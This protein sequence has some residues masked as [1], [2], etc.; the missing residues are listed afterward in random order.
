MLRSIA[1]SWNW[2]SNS[3]IPLHLLLLL[4]L[5]AVVRVCRFVLCPS[6][7]LALDSAFVRTKQL[8]IN[9]RL[10]ALFFCPPSDPP[11]HKRCVWLVPAFFCVKR[12]CSHSET[13]E[14]YVSSS[15][16]QGW[17]AEALDVH[18]LYLIT[19][20]RWKWKGEGF[21]YLQLK[22]DFSHNP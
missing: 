7:Q 12:K 8:L 20:K 9:C 15:S 18:G 2:Y 16:V 10:S 3:N 19:W 13:Y 5:D 21:D 14:S 6:C 1:L 4:L 11:I 22:N 17:K